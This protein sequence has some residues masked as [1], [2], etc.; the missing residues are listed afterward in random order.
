MLEQIGPDI[1]HVQHRFKVAGMPLTSRMTVVR[2]Q[3]ERLWLHSPIALDDQ[4]K[5]ELR[6]LGQVAYIVA[7]NKMHHL[8]AGPCARAYPDALLYGAPGLQQ[9]RPD[10]THMI[11]LTPCMPEAWQPELS[12][13]FVAGLPFG[14]ETV[15]FHHPSKTLIVTD[16]VQW[17]AGDLPAAARF[18]GWLTGVRKQLAIPWSIRLLIKDKAAMCASARQIMQWPIERVLYAHNGIIDNNARAA[19]QAAFACLEQS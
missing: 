4:L 15:W 18:Y 17:W 10:L 1:W 8:F 6:Q 11:T 19:L 14:N 7:P 13:V 12:Q 16:F 9:K 3:G 5:A 2:L